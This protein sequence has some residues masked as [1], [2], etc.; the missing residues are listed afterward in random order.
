LITF[1][2]QRLAN[3]I[4]RHAFGYGYGCVTG[5][6]AGRFGDPKALGHTSPDCHA[7]M[8]RVSMLNALLCLQVAASEEATVEKVNVTKVRVKDG[9]VECG[10]AVHRRRGWLYSTV[11]V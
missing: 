9:F 1:E 7:E 11:V 6:R 8:V 5:G 10:I 2:T 3:A 4:Y